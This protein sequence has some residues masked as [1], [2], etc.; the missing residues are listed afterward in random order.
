M[1]RV[2]CRDQMK[3]IGWRFIFENF[4][5]MTNLFVPMTDLK[6]KPKPMTDLKSKPMILNLILNN[7]SL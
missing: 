7:V 4:I 6:S 1:I 3:Q 5:K 2:L